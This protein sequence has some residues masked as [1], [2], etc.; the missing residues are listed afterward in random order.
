MDASS[1]CTFLV[2]VEFCVHRDDLPQPIDRYVPI[3]FVLKVPFDFV[4]S[5]HKVP[6]DVWLDLVIH[7]L[8]HLQG[9]ELGSGII[10]VHHLRDLC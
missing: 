8:Q 6:W 5:L 2:E 10:G 4:T 3:M 1:S 9:I 7:A